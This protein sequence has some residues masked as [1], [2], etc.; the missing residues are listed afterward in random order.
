[1]TPS[2]HLP[3]SCPRP[4][5]ELGLGTPAFRVG[6]V[7]KRRT[8]LNKRTDLHF[9]MDVEEEIFSEQSGSR[10]FYEKKKQK[11]SLS[12]IKKIWNLTIS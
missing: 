7:V 8:H 2:P 5:P 10:C 3:V 4:E 6:R 11:R 12:F 1:M 9:R